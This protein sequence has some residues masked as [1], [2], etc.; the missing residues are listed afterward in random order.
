MGAETVTTYANIL[1]G[2]SENQFG[3]IVD[4]DTVLIQNLPVT[5][6][7]TGKTVQDPSSPTPRT[8][9]QIY[10]SVPDYIGL[11]N[12]DRLVD[13]ATGDTYIVIDVTRPPTLIGAPVDTVASLKRISAQTT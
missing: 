1:R 10:C 3:D 6:I 9:R 2:T 13:L 4:S 8:I 12:T 5:L 11:V 7:E